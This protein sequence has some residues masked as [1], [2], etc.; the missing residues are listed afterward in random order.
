MDQEYYKRVVQLE[1]RMNQM[2]VTIQALL[3]RLGIDQ[4][5]VTPQEQPETRAIHEALLAGNKIK[6]IALY[7]AL[8]NVGLKEA[9]DAIDSM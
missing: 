7:R 4:A 2:D 3:T 8:Y 5:E 1:A 6:A 9:K